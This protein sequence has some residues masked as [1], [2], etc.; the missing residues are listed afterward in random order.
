PPSAQPQNDKELSPHPRP[1]D[2]FSSFPKTK[3]TSVSS[4]L[5]STY[6]I[7]TVFVFGQKFIKKFQKS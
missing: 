7:A 5:T 2:P 4:F 3:Q 1:S 6:I